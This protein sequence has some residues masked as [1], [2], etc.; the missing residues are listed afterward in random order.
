MN[1]AATNLFED[2]KKALTDLK[3]FLD[4]NV[5]KIK[6]AVQ[7]LDQLTGG[8]IS[9]LIDR[10]IALL[11]KLKAGIDKLDPGLVPGLDDVTKFSQNIKSL[12]S[13]SK[14]LLP[15]EAD[16]IKEIEDVA[17]IVTSLPSIDQLKTEIKSL[18]DAIK[19]HLNTLKS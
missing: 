9:D 11:D 14:S 17:N 8:R 6:P 1:M 12:L 18:I 16:S 7:P 19:G 5:G 4:G 2:L 13:A 3:E 10:L 15:D